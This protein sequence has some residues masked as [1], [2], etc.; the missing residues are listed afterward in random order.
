MA[1]PANG[2]GLKSKFATHQIVRCKPSVGKGLPTY[3]AVTHRIVGYKP[4]VGK[5]LPTF[6][7]AFGAS[8]AML[9]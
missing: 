5:G 4:Q 8:T 2:F 1:R 9:L 7:A 6:C 3:G